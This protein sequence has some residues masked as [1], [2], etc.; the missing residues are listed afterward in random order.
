[1]VLSTATYPG[2]AYWLKIASPIDTQIHDAIANIRQR[3]EAGVPF[4]TKENIR[5]L[6]QQLEF[7][8]KSQRFDDDIVVSV[9][10]LDEKVVDFKIES[11][12]VLTLD[13][14]GV[15]RVLYV[16][17]ITQW[18]KIADLILEHPHS[19]ITFL[20]S[21]SCRQNSTMCH[22]LLYAI[23]GFIIE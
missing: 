9:E 11:G 6:A 18:V 14:M 7:A 23:C 15:E 1:M 20:C 21:S 3:Y 2:E 19:F 13:R 8:Q 5:K 16:I 10:A 22:A 4:Y 17:S 12:R